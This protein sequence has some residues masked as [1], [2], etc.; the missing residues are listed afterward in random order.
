LTQQTGPAAVWQVKVVDVA[1]GNDRRP[2]HRLILARNRETGERKYFVTNA[3]RRLG[4]RRV[5]TAGFVRWNV[6]HVFRVAKSEVGLTHFEG[7]SYVSLQ[8]HVALCL[9]V[10]A[11]VSLHTLQLR[12]EKCGGHPGAGLHGLGPDLPEIPEPAAGDV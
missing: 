4:V 8:R 1:L 3:R 10:L 6:E 12:G 5:L 2:R 11:F 9:V 7:R